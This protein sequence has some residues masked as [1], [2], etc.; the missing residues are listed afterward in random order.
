M[1]AVAAG[2]DGAGCGDFE[3]LI[4]VAPTRQRGDSVIPRKR[5]I[6]TV[7]WTLPGFLWAAAFTAGV[8]GDD[9]SDE[10]PKCNVV[11]HASVNAI[12]PGKPF[13][14]GLQ[15]QLS[16]GW[17]I[18][19]KN[20]GDSGKAPSVTWTAPPGFSFGELSYP[21]PKR[22][23]SAGNI[24]TNILEGEPV[25]LSTVMPPAA[26]S[27]KSVTL[28]ADVRYLICNE[29]CL[30]ESAKVH[31]MM[32][33]AEAGTE[34]K[35]ANES[36]FAKARKSLPSASSA[37]L[38]VTPRVQP[39]ALAPGGDF[40]LKV[41]IDIK[42]GFH[43]QS[44]K[45][46]NPLFI[47]CDVFL[48][49]PDGV[50]WAE[51]VFPA[52][53]FRE[54]K[55]V[56]KVSEFAGAVPVRV[57][58]K[59]ESSV[60]AGPLPL[61]GVV[62]YQACDEKGTCFPP[63]AVAFAASASVGATA[64]SATAVTPKGSAAPKSDGVPVESSPPAGERNVDQADLGAP[65]DPLSATALDEDG[66]ERFLKRFGLAGILLGCFLYGLAINATPCVLPLLSIKVLG[67][68]HQAHE[69][70]RRT[71]SLALAFGTGV[72]I[73]FVI[74]GF[75]ASRGQNLLGNPVAVIALGSVVMALALS[76]LGVYTLQPPSAATKL[77]AHLRR[78]DVFTSFGKGALAP[79]LGLACTAPFMAGMFALAS[80]QAPLIAF[81]AFAV[82]GLGMASPYILLGA[83]PHWLSFLPKPGNWMI[84][85]ERIM[86]FLLLAMT[87]LLLH[88]LTALIGVPG[89]EWTLVFLVI[90]GMG[91]W[92]WGRMNY[93]MSRG[94]RLKIRAGAVSLIAAGVM[95]IYGW[96]Y[97]IG[98]AR[99]RILAERSNGNGAN[100]VENSLIAW[101][102]W[103]EQAVRQA[104]SS[105][106]AAFVDFTAAYCTNCKV[107]KAVA[108][109]QPETAEKIKSL[110]IVPFQ[111]DFTDNDPMIFATLQA[112]ER[113]GVPL[114]LLYLPG[115]PDQP[116]RFPVLF[117]KRFLLEQLDRVGSKAVSASL[118]P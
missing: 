92:L 6:A 69:S 104:V 28:D 110:S 56:G 22:N 17:H 53:K 33:V 58:G 81:L 90:V 21:V 43:I 29:T 4:F 109:N 35:P 11:L 105:G 73:F 107:N 114:N 83:N 39:E 95:V 30:I 66:W 63:D 48:E 26:L 91:C 32:P 79:I 38:T 44:N 102:P 67:F 71:F 9:F 5:L 75:L 54:L 76:M 40:E 16:S 2:F 116:I 55:Y 88:P 18:Y 93:S 98:D 27:E 106:K 118:T 94:Q 100:V 8:R 34:P 60:P 42:R 86:G 89:L 51:P 36:L 108:I 70:R 59:L 41:D 61:A 80:R 52:P 24:V 103:S 10:A 78:E 68:V 49:R 112:Q 50:S 57:A 87:V 1:A 46:L 113:Q 111:G 13:D 23:D 97:P 77:E 82:T 3:L 84:T 19:W 15:F 64:G 20:S 12:T 37:Y 31:L 65:G 47:A 62:R 7:T 101:Q 45:P 25:L 115:R 74:L 72:V 99:S 96:A 117:S 14:L 85:F